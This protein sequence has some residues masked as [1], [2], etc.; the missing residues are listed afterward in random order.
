MDKPL[1]ITCPADVLLKDSFGMSSMLKIYRYLCIWGK[2]R[3]LTV[4]VA[5][6]PHFIVVVSFTSA[7]SL[8]GMVILVGLPL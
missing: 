5:S 7:V 2:G 1:E 6:S 4:D 3:A 8:S